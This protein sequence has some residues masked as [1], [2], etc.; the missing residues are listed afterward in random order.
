MW[1]L[2]GD[3]LKSEQLPFAKITQSLLQAHTA[4]YHAVL[5]AV[6]YIL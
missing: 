3:R 1:G 4:L 2:E 6:G 5:E